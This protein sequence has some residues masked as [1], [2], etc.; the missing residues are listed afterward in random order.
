MI[1]SSDYC[2]NMHSMYIRTRTDKD[3]SSERSHLIGSLSTSSSSNSKMK[4]IENLC[5]SKEKSLS[6]HFECTHPFLDNRGNLSSVCKALS[7]LSLVGII[8]GS[9]MPKNRELHTPCYRYV[10]SIIGYTYFMFWCVSF[11]PQ[12]IL[13]FSRKSTEGLSADFSVI[14]F[15]GYICYAI[16][17]CALYWNE[18]IKELYRDRHK[19]ELSEGGAKITVE[20]NDV[21]FALH[22][23]LF[24]AIWQFQLFVYGGMDSHRGSTLMN[25]TSVII[26]LMILFSTSLYAVLIC[27]KGFGIGERGE[28]GSNRGMQQPLMFSEYLN[29]LDFI[30]F[31][32]YIKVFITLYKYVPQLALNAR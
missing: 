10:S 16:Y 3:I 21:A 31:L 24:S 22:A 28:P 2:M 9:M 15:I 11:Y 20:N 7:Y 5:P 8:I 32:S 18:G 1:P 14:N 29:W 4:N 26:I 12:I 23:V 27:W 13:N 17:N 30:Y 6:S 19:S 25:K